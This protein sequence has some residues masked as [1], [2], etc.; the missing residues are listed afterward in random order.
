MSNCT[1]T[2]IHEKI[3]NYSAVCKF[4]NEN[5]EYSYINFYNLHY[6]IL[7]QNIYITFPI[8][9]LSIYI[10]FYLLSDTSNKYLSNALTILSDKM[11]MSQTLAGVTLLALGNGA[12]DVISSIVASGNDNDVSFSLAAL[13]G[14]GIFVSG[15][16]LA[17]VIV[18]SKEVKVNKQ[19]F[20]RDLILYIL[21]LLVLI[22]F[23]FVKRIGIYESVTFFLLYFIN[24]LITIF[25]TRSKK[26]SENIMEDL[27][28]L[29][30]ESELQNVEEFVK[31]IFR[32]QPSKIEN[33]NENQQDVNQFFDK[34]IKDDY[35]Y[36]KESSNYN[37]ITRDS[38][39]SNKIIRSS[40]LSRAFSFQYS[41]FKYKLK[42][43]YFNNLENKWED[44]S[45]I[46]KI[47]FLFIDL[48]FNFFR[49][50][51]I[52]PTELERWN[53]MIFITMPFSV[54][55]FFILVTQSNIF[56]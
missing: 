14:G 23:S 35:F 39:S 53:R 7:E 1:H 29:K 3:G 6:C 2:L 45:F 8:L 15:I 47:T 20:M 42:K 21:V 55:M 31:N 11:K 24:V 16:V 40:T 36:S 32:T 5:C 10:C 38:Y 51:T 44:K 50:I 27:I 41:A 28:E 25:Q 4:V 52:P 48:P 17:S 22:M 30:D 18:F 46:S 33:K 12:P 26:K 9:C 37:E 49:D 19:L 54:V 34:S 56:N 43:H 13:I